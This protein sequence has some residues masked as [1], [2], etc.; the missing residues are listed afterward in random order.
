[1]ICSFKCW[2]FEL[3]HN[4]LRKLKQF[5][6]FTSPPVKAKT[7]YS[8]RPRLRSQGRTLLTEPRCRNP[9][10]LRSFDSWLSSICIIDFHVICTDLSE[11]ERE[12]ESQVEIEKTLILS[13]CL[14][15]DRWP[16]K[17]LQGQQQQ[18][19]IFG[20][21]FIRLLLN[22]RLLGVKQCTMATSQPTYLPS[23][24]VYI[25]S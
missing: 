10:G 5:L 16:S 25:S 24:W 8:I 7:F 22:P 18:L 17:I 14:L 23:M 21:I 11:W 15:M 3:I 6:L 9:E 12:I 20:L 2:L 13:L 4:C 19:L 1:M